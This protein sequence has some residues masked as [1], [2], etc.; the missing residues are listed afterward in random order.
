MHGAALPCPAPGGRTLR[1]WLVQFVDCSARARGR[2]G[3]HVVQ[4]GHA[5]WVYSIPRERRPQSGKI[6]KDLV[7]GLLVFACAVD[8]QA[9]IPSPLHHQWASFRA[10]LSLPTPDRMCV[11]T[12]AIVPCHRNVNRNMRDCN[13]SDMHAHTQMD[14]SRRNTSSSACA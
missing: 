8:L 6:K 4:Y 13:Y 2:A 9:L 7:T 14:G 5:S 10:R 1:C 12:A 3:T 11:R